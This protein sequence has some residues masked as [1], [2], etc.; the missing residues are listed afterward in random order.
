MADKLD[1]IHFTSL[2]NQD[3]TAQLLALQQANLP[4]NIST[5]IATSQ[6]FVTVQHK[7]GLLEE[8]NRAIPQ[9][10]AKAGGKVIGYA[11]AMLPSFAEKVPVLQPMFSLFDAIEY[12][13]RKVSDYRYYVMGQVCVAEG[14]RGMGVFDG[15]YQ[16]HKALFAPAYDFCIT[17][18]SSRNTR[19]LRAHQ[20]VGFKSI[21]CYRDATDEWDIV[22]WDWA[23]R[24]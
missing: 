17:E 5:E 8:M 1:Q 10:I 24:V 15:L 12:R 22:L 20:R 6:G 13:Q 23:D 21:H 18:I 7:A 11:L 9:V 16:K 2:G 4:A 19:S 14:Y 3:E